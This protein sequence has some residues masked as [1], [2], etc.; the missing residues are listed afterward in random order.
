M[1]YFVLMCGLS[2]SGKS[3]F[4]QKLKEKGYE[5]LSSDDLR[6]ELWGDASDQQKPGLVFNELNK[7][8]VEKLRAGKNV[9][10]DATNTSAKRRERLLNVI[11]SSCKEKVYKVCAMVLSHPGLCVER[12]R[13]REERPVEPRVVIRQLMNFE[14]PHFIEGWD[15]I[16]IYCNSVGS[17]VLPHLEFLRETSQDNMHHSL[18]I[19][20]HMEKAAAIAVN[21]P[22]ITDEADKDIVYK[23]ARYH[24]IG[25]Y[26]TKVFRDRKGNFSSEAHYFGHQNVG[27]Y[28][29]LLSEIK[30]IT[31]YF[32]GDNVPVLDTALLILHHMDHFIYEKVGLARLYQKLGPRLTQMLLAV[33]KADIDAH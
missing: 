32:K 6:Q 19:G 7:R 9:V 24:D 1:P 17:F 22:R 14:I 4:A 20:E 16:Q 15:E 3:T 13:F 18:S 12:A 33:E 8:T 26:F 27:A 21:S 10:Y 5:V 23:A 2:G 30:G 31:V 28:F 29:Y 11:N 25:K